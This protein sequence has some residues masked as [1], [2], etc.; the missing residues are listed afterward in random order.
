VDGRGVS[1]FGPIISQSLR[2]AGLEVSDPVFVGSHVCDVLNRQTEDIGVY[3]FGSKFSIMFFCVLHIY[4]TNK[5][6]LNIIWAIDFIILLNCL[7]YYPDNK[8]NLFY[9]LLSFDFHNLIL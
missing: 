1:L 7:F 8:I 6:K 5:H 3:G 9:T 4:H 2:V